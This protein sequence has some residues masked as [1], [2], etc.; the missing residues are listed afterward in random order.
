MSVATMA[1]CGANFVV[2]VSFLTLLSAI[3]NAG[4]FFLFAG[5]SIAA[6]TYFQRKV[7]ETRNRSL[8]DI[9]RD[10]G[11]RPVLWPAPPLSQ[12]QAGRETSPRG[13]GH[14]CR[15]QWQHAPG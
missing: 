12:S 14:G 2:A 6:V 15:C 13:R 7:P 4:T 9:E 5:L 3:G 8:Q 1:N 11:P 10:L